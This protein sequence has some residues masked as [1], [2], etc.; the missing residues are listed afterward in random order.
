MILVTGAAGYIGSHFV[1]KYLSSVPD[2]SVL[3]VDNL[4]AGHIESLPLSDRV[5]FHQLNVGDKEVLSELMKKHQIEAVVHFAASIFVGESQ[6]DPFKYFNNNL[7]QTMALLEA[8]SLANVKKIVFSSTCAT[9]G[10]PLQVPMTETH[11]QVPI[12]AYGHTKYMVEQMLYSLHETLG[13][14]FFALRY[15]NA[16]GAD[17]NGEIGESHDPETHLIPNVFRAISGKLDCLEVYG[18]DYDTRDGTCIRDYI[19]VYDLASAHIA[20]L[21]LLSKGSYAEGINLGTGHGAS[22]KEIIDACNEAAGKTA[23]MKLFP[24]RFGDAPVLVA[25]YAKAKKVLGWS[26]RYELKTII[27]SAW[28]WELNRRY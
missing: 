13:F 15:F 12:N 2:G 11:P 26:P 23:P 3:A 18:D 7:G 9:Y 21:D 1:R 16:A 17:D 4:S 22:V 5:I 25:D 6:K 20:A 19:H 24:R 27:K 10:D 8:M 28:N 14:S